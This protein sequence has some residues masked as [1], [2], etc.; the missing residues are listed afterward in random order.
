MHVKNGQRGGAL[1]EFAIIAPVLF[2]FLMGSF[3]FGFLIYEYHATN[4]AAKSAA[5]WGSVR[6]ANCSDASCPATS[7]TIKTFVT[8]SVPGL[9]TKSSLFK[10][11]TAWASPV[12]ANYPGSSTVTCSSAAQ[13]QGC[14]ITVTVQ[15]PVT[16]H[17]PLLHINPI[18][19]TSTSTAV[20]Q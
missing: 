9:Q 1:V 18:T 10:V 4:Y 20:V 11:T 13:A 12:P 19:L 2:M 14:L 16:V 5:R 7:A 15:N 8:S 3:E 6:G 17:I